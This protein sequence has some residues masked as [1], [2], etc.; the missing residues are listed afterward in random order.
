MI[1]RFHMFAIFCLFWAAVAAAQEG[2]VRVRASL[3]QPTV[4][5]EDVVQLTVSAT[6]AYNLQTINVKFPLLRDFDKL[7]EQTSRSFSQVN[8]RVT[9]TVSIIYNLYPKRRGTFTI[10]ALEVEVG[11][12]TYLTE[13]LTVTVTESRSGNELIVRYSPSTR[14]AWV[15]EQ[16]TLDLELLFRVRVSNYEIADEP[17]LEGFIVVQD[18]PANPNATIDEVEYQGQVYNRAVLRRQMLFPLSSG[19]K[20]LEP[21]TFRIYY[22]TTGFDFNT[23]IASR[24]TERVRI[25]VKPL[26]S[27][28]PDSFSGAVGAYKLDWSVDPIAGK[29]GEPVT[30][31]I[32][33]TGRGDIER[34]PDIRPPLPEG[35]EIINAATSAQTVNAD[36]VWGGEKRW[37]YIVIPD[38]PGERPFGPLEFSYFNPRTARYE[39]L[40]AP[41]VNLSI[42]ESERPA[43]LAIPTPE[44]GDER[45]GDIRY[46]K[47]TP[48]TFTHNGE[49]I[50]SAPWFWI[51]LLV[52]L[53]AN[54]AVLAVTS[55]RRNGGRDQSG[56]RR[57]Q[58]LSTA[59]A[60]LEKARARGDASSGGFEQV[61]MAVM[62]YFA[63][64][65][66]R[67]G[68][69][70]S[71]GE[72]RELL[73]RHDQHASEA[74]EHLARIVITCEASRYAPSALQG[75]SPGRLASEAIQHLENLDA[76]L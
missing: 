73:V 38:T 44:P 42:A 56:A 12:A 28:A 45:E 52:P 68:I 58:A 33:L 74:F 63:D 55:L 14:S 18:L 49:S 72:V 34:A 17:T 4:S 60:T 53:L 20:Y 54:A 15:G 39:S 6:A 36:G 61:R 30:V 32:V 26:P 27:G 43:R 59:R 5:E 75:A 69:E 13:P 71:L 8:N 11:G 41:A 23:R 47:S 66:E 51:A 35:F 22:R 1:R 37:E 31:K 29:A 50:T 7:G 76:S 21:L 40:T 48:G 3:S 19:E 57:R 9:T 25:D 70:L 67:P 16:I 2:E 64:K 65:F 10:P 24:K 46:L 62:R